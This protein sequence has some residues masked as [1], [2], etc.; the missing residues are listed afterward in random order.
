MFNQFTRQLQQILAAPVHQLNAWIAQQRQIRARRRADQ[1][2]T[3]VQAI[4]AEL[5]RRDTPPTEPQI[6]PLCHRQSL[7]ITF[8]LLQTA[9][10]INVRCPHCGR[11]S[12]MH[13]RA[14]PS[15]APRWVQASKRH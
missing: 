3:A 8:T 2:A 15:S 10:S 14:R 12:V 4:I 6:C 5:R 1:Y 7:R 11:K 9:L 13:I